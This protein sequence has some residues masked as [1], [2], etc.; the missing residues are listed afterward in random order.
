VLTCEV[1]AQRATSHPSIT[2][3]EKGTQIQSRDSALVAKKAT[4][5]QASVFVAANRFICSER[6]RK[7]CLDLLSYLFLFLCHVITGFVRDILLSAGFQLQLSLLAVD[8]S[9][10]GIRGATWL[11]STVCAAA[12]QFGVGRRVINFIMLARFHIVVPLLQNPCT[13]YN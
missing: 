3:A 2:A 11:V 13:V 5:H 10:A 7:L 9:N 8:I 12:G 6:I 1:V 4:G